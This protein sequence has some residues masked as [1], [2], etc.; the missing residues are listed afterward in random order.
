VGICADIKHGATKPKTVEPLPLTICIT[1][2]FKPTPWK[3]PS[4]KAIRYDSQVNEKAAFAILAV[5]EL[6]K[7]GVVLN[8]G[9]PLFPNKTPLLV[10]LVF[11]FAL[12]K[13][14]GTPG[15]PRAD[16]DNL[17]KFVMDAMQS[18]SLAG[19]IWHDDDQVVSLLSQKCYGSEDSIEIYI[20]QRKTP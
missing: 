11:S 1:V 18:Q 12:Q 15:Y 16:V 6:R 5:Q 2:P 19:C 10:N 17:A 3:R 7:T 9:Q 4:G 13:K 14:I 20:R 8:A